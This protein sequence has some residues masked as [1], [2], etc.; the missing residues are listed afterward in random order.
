[1][2]TVEDPQPADGEVCNSELRVHGVARRVYFETLRVPETLPSPCMGNLIA[3]S[4]TPGTRER[5]ILSLVPDAQN[6]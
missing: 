4:A 1:M 6:L 2:Y 3:R 5:V